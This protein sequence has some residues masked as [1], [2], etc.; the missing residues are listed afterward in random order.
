MFVYELSGRGFESRC[1]HSSNHHHK[2]IMLYFL[3]TT[4]GDY[5][6]TKLQVSINHVVSTTIRRLCDFTY[7]LCRSWNNSVCLRDATLQSN[8]LLQK[9]F[10]RV[11]SNGAEQLYC[12]V[13]KVL[14]N[15][16]F[17]FCILYNA[18][19]RLLLVD[20]NKKIYW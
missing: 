6:L 15:T 19:Q 1:S 20:T 3:T 10:S 12:N 8:K 4:C 14:E 13:E 16:Y 11:L 18:F 7:T 2:T 9:Y 17:V 5:F